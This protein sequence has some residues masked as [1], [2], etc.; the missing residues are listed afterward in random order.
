VNWL[1]SLRTRLIVLYSGLILFGF[2]G[3]A[4]W[5]GQ[6]IETAAREDFE[7]RAESEVAI[8]SRALIE[9]VEHYLEGELQLDGVALVLENYAR[10]T[11]S[12][13]TLINNQGQAWLSTT[14]P[15]D[16]ISYLNLPEITTARENRITHETRHDASGSL[17]IYTA[18][19]VMEEGRVTSIVQLVSPLDDVQSS[20]QRRWMAL[21]LGGAGLGVVVM[22][23]SVLI[24]ASLTRPLA[25]MRQ[26]AIQISEGDFS[27]HLPDQRR[28][29]IGQVAQTFNTMSRRVQ[30]MLEEQRAFASNAS[31]ELRTPLTTVGL[32]IE[33]L[34]ADALPAEKQR[35]YLQEVEAE[36]RRMKNLIDDLILLSRFDAGSVEIGRDMVDMPRFARQLIKEMQPQ[37]DERGITITLYADDAVPPVRANLTHLH[38]VFRN[39][40]D[41]AIKY[42]EDSGGAIQ[43]HVQP[44]DGWLVSII[45]DTGKGI[46]ADELAHVLKRFYRADRAHSRAVP[47]AGLGLSLVQSIVDAYGG[48]FTLDSQGL[49]AGTTVR[50]T[51]P[52]LT[53]TA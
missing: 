18:A 7:H 15:A 37:A 11:N 45:T 34:L 32:R 53:G 23:V 9:P 8:V 13:L 49:G 2:G 24:S 25:R 14:T 5:A 39:I 22:V 16:G 20:I 51:W 50:V 47:G 4:L 31:H 48:E 1:Y 43:W 33:A 40:L 52:A 38:V 44:E 28:D 10:Q 17:M 42:M 29:E 35:R 3:L 41:N 46:D 12:E 19:P 27:A 30:A 6:Q 26:A 21:G 36:I